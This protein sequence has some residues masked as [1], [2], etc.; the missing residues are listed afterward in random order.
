M[1]VDSRS[2]KWQITVNNPLDKGFTHEYI[3]KQFEEFKNLLY[4][5]MCDEISES[6]TYHTHFFIVCSGAV[7]FSRMKKL[8]EGAHFEMA[9]GTSQENRDYIRKEGKWEKDKKKETNLIDTF[10]EFG[11]MPVERPGQRNDIHDLYDMIRS[12][13]TNFDIIE[14]NPDYMMCIDKIEKTRQIIR[15]EEYKR[16]FRKLEVTYIWGS[17]GSGKTRGVMEKYGYENVYRITD[18]QHPF[19]GY[20]GQDVIV[21]EEF[22]SSL[23]IS[24]MLL[25]LDGYPTELP[26]RYFNK[27]ACFT[28]VYILT[29][30]DLESQY[31]DVQLSHPE[32]WLAFK[33][34]INEVVCTDEEL[35]ESDIFDSPFVAPS[36][37]DDLKLSD[38]AQ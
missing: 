33:R 6:G 7:R 21:F 15:E 16:V 32:T 11:E 37:D 23:K 28:K 36:Y 5:C 27:V 30:H 8:F 4:W 35:F 29:N 9:R 2:R 19:D 12:G 13:M 17:T 14:Q 1:K 20:K 24:E 22:R 34:R 25:Y 31:R 3:K 26:C 18:Y 38:F 10:E